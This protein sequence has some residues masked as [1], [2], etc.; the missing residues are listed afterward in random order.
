MNELRWILLGLGVLVIAGIYF[1][2]S[3]KQKR[4]LRSRIENYPS[5][6]KDSLSN[7]RINPK[8]E[9]NID[10]SGALATFNSY[11][12]QSRKSTTDTDMDTDAVLSETGTEEYD[13]LDDEAG[14]QPV[15]EKNKQQEIMVIYVTAES[16]PEF[17]GQDIL[18]ALESADMQF[19][20]MDIFH[21]H[22]PDKNHA[23]RALFSLANIHEPGSFDIDNMNRFSTNGLALFM[24]LPA[25]IGGDIAFEIMLDTAHNLAY[26][27]GGELRGS[28]RKILDTEKLNK[29]REIAGRY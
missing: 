23:T 14:D 21:Y 4:N 6:D 27:L 2:E 19:G 10:I 28:D 1:W 12:K 25:D 29:I 24:C 13:F 16:S 15:Q 8:K 22:G 20:D 18:H 5:T 7:I 9:R 11:L 26:L 17:K 3:T